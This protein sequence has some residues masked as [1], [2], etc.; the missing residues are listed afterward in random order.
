MHLTST[1]ETQGASLL[2]SCS[3]LRSNS[4]TAKW[5]LLILYIFTLSHIGIREKSVFLS[6]NSGT[7]KQL[8]WF[9]LSLIFSHIA[10]C[11]NLVFFFL[12]AV[13]E[14]MQIYWIVFIITYS[15]ISIC[16]KFVF[17]SSDSGAA[18]W[19][20]CSTYQY[21]ITHLYLWNFCLLCSDWGTAKY[22]L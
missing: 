13:T 9:C 18:K 1:N 12:S 20:L 4:G 22:P 14:V 16:V 2:P 10:I 8:L 19:P 3:F 5:P 11:G 21:I 15:H 6:D 17:L 7:A